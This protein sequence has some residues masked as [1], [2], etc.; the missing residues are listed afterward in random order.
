MKAEEILKELQLLGSEQTKK[1]LMNHGAKEPLFGVK[2]GDMKPIQKRIKKDYQLSMDLFASG[3]SDAMYL[4]G[5]IADESKMS[6][7]DINHWAYEATWH[8]ISEHTV[9]WV[10]TESNFGW[11]LALEWIESDL[12]HVASSGW[13][14]LADLVSMKSNEEIDKNL[15]NSLLERVSR[16]IHQSKNRVRYTMNG[17]LISVGS[18]MPDFTEKSKEIAK[19]IGV[20]DVF[21]GKTACKVPSAVEYID[22]VLARNGGSVAKKKKTVKC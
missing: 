22:K 20:V 13:A 19:N 16:E 3:N 12:E 11:E 17:F 1:T 14:T 8:M 18:Y 9:S 15:I 10:A 6:K 7:E 5:L 21:M 2:V 4:A